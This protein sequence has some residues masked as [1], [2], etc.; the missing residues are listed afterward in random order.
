MTNKK[1]HHLPNEARE[2]IVK[3]LQKA[4]STQSDIVF[5]YLYGSFGDGL[6]YHDIDVGLYLEAGHDRDASSRG[7]GL[8]ALLSQRAGVPVDVRIL[9]HAPIP[10]MYHVIRGRLLVDNDPGLRARIAERVVARY[11]DMKS[12]LRHATKE[13][14]AA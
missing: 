2:P 14:F 9:N 5:A 12:V 13:A 3:A 8:A 10:F 11:L 4:L 1:L 6:P 7:L